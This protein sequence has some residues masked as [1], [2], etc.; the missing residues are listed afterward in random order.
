MIAPESF[1]PGTLTIVA[2]FLAALSGVPM[3]LSPPPSAKSQKLSALLL[4]A[5]AAMGVGSA[6]ATLLSGRTEA[7]TLLW[8]LPFG[9]MEAALDPLSALFLIPVF[10]VSGCC[11]VYGLRYW[12]ASE[13][14]RTVRKLTLFLGLLTASMAWVLLARDGILFL[15]A[16]EIMALSAWFVLTTD[17]AQEP[18]REAGLLYMV[19]THV[20]TLT[21]FAL[22][23][24]L[25]GASGAFL[26]PAAGSLP[27]AGEFSARL[28]LVALVGF[29]LKAGLMP[30]HIWLPSAHANAPSHVSAVMS[31]VILKI[32]VYGMV[33]TLSFFA[34]VPA[35]WGIA[36]LMLGVFSGVAGVAFA[37]AQ[38]DLK[39]LLA[40][41]SIENIGIIFMGIGVALIGQATGNAA[42]ALL[43]MAGALLHVVNHSTFKALLF[44]CAG[45]AI[46]ASGTREIDRMGG[47]ARRLPWT[48]A[49]FLVGAVA[50]CGLPPL[51]GFVSEFLVYLGLFRGVL[52]N[53]VATA[54][55]SALAAP[56]L[57]LVGGLATACF[58]KVYGV[59][60]LGEPRRPPHGGDH[61]EAREMVA[62]MA[63]LAA[64]CATIG[65]VPLSVARMLDQAVLVWQPALAGAGANVRALAPLGWITALALGLASLA[66]VSMWLLIR[67][68]R[69]TGSSA[70]DT[71]G[72]GYLAPTARMQYTASSFAGMVVDIFGGILRPHRDSRPV[73]GQF[74]GRSRF[75]SHV[76]E[77]VLEL[78]YMPLL[79]KAYAKMAGIRKTQSGRLHLYILYMFV[80]LVLMLSL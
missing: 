48:A 8:S 31:G 26:F 50:I 14:P 18:V 35:W 22:F 2:S 19:T 79:E 38:H 13:N 59:V 65:L 33:R 17:D 72:C 9:R 64:V 4:A 45:S 70:S 20:S 74:P 62:P 11:G 34:G 43:G 51:N 58:V 71:W 21:L 57:A 75:G 15:F 28:F 44:L 73:E 37:I 12:P 80:T 61:G 32:G 77:A 42:L 25:A 30:F 78:V 68:I 52:G 5:A 69:A 23:A 24:M 16:W 1:S 60:F 63:L 40:Y 66:A 3:L 6:I 46:H 10:L 39:R 76:P 41:H 55:F 49:F 7:F 56:A 27:G 36:L 47:L 54:A 53:H 67:R 29:G